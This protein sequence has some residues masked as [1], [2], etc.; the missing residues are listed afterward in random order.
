MP[1]VVVAALAVSAIIACAYA[2][3]PHHRYFQSTLHSV[4]SPPDQWFTQNIDH[5]DATAGTFQQRFQTNTTW[6]KPGGPL[7]LMLGGEGPANGGWIGMD[8][9]VMVYAEEHSA[10]VAQLGLVACPLSD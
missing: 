2:R 6:Y 4:H 3:K 9:A 5:F 1:S 7:F 10:V 8:T